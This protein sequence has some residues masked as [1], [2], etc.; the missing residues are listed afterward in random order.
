MT[1]AILLTLLA[2]FLVVAHVWK[3]DRRIVALEDR[4]LPPQQQ[5]PYCDNC[6]DTGLVCENHPGL[7]WA[8][9]CG[10]IFACGCGAG[11][12]CPSCTWPIPQDGKHSITEAFKPGADRQ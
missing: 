6:E 10:A 7:P 1:L 9:A 2:M 4:D 8:G 5:F 11:M 12:P 3:L